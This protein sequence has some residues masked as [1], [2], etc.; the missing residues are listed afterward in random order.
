[1]GLVSNYKNPFSAIVFLFYVLVQNIFKTKLFVILSKMAS[2]FWQ[3]RCGAQTFLL[4]QGFFLRA[5]FYDH[6][7]PAPIKKCLSLGGIHQD[8]HCTLVIFPPSQEY[9]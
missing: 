1:M 8:Q 3:Q 9:R 7:L 5:F 6:I 4:T 2:I